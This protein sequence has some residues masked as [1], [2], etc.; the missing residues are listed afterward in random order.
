[1]QTCYEQLTAGGF[2]NALAML[3]GKAAVPAQRERYARAVA[4][5]TD[6]FG[7]RD[8]VWLL[9]APGRTEL[10]G[11]HTDHNHGLALAGAVDMDIIAAAAPSGG[12]QVRVHS[13]GFPTMTVSLDTREVDPAERGKSTALIRGM[14]AGMQ[15][16]GLPIGGF[17]MVTD[18]TVP[19]GAGLSSSAAFEL[20]IGTAFDHLF[21]DGKLPPVTL[22]RIAQ[23]AE[24][25][26]FGKPSGLLDQLGCAVGGAIEIDF[27]DPSEP[28]V[29]AFPFQPADHGYR[30]CI[31]N[32]RGDH[33]NLT[34]DYA[35]VTREMRAVSR[36]LKVK[37]LRETSREAVLAHLP[38]LRRRHG[39]RAVL[40]ALHFFDENERV[41]AQA[42]ALKADDFE[43]FRRL[44]AQSGRSS[45]EFLQN[46]YSVRHPKQQGLPL[47]LYLAQSL[48]GDEGAWRVHGG[49]FAGTTQNYVPIDRMPAF[50]K[51]MEAA[52]GEGCCYEMNLR[53]VGG[54]QVNMEK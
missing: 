39:D 28:Q 53:P 23:H 47:A 33:A 54:V 34:D 31:V 38:M 18:S 16:L 12:N 35:A 2:D 32:T 8:R 50:R 45:F 13:E 44:V 3:Y 21:G 5:F 19:K 29:Q 42:A 37:F 49:G 51:A 24:N 40:R 22:A 11:N 20:L 41:K 14:A 52:F 30:L 48:L 15:A 27:A 17:D 1:M 10:G 25:A 43:A 9:S 36:S 4:S 26:Y 7:K 46:V 6:M